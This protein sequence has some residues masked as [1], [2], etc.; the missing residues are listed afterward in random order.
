MRH[1]R[2]MF[3]KLQPFAIFALVLSAC[4]DP[5]SSELA[6][7]NQ[8]QK[9]PVDAGYVPAD[10]LLPNGEFNDTRCQAVAPSPVLTVGGRTVTFQAD[11]PGPRSADWTALKPILDPIAPSSAL[12]V[13]VINIVRVNGKPYFRYLSNGTQNDTVQTWSSSKPLA[14]A[15]MASQLR[16]ESNGLVGID[17]STRS[18]NGDG[19][20]VP[21]GD[22]VSIATVYRER[23]RPYNSNNIGTWAQ[24]VSGR[25]HTTRLI[26]TW[27]KRPN[28]TLGGGY[29]EDGSGLTA[30]FRSPD[31]REHVSRLS[32]SGST[33]NQ[34][35]TLTFADFYRRIILH[36]ELREQDLTENR[37]TCDPE[38]MGSL[39]LPCVTW[40]D[41]KTILYGASR[42]TTRYFRD[43][44]VGGMAGGMSTLLHHA[45]TAGNPQ[46]LNQRFQGK[47]RIFTKVGWGTSNGLPDTRWHGYGCFPVFDPTTGA[48][49][50]QGKEFLISVALKPLP[51]LTTAQ[52][53]IILQ[54]AVSAITSKLLDGSLK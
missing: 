43:K 32:A 13:T 38:R 23:V 50:A 10:L 52:A 54:K 25:P 27:L 9:N 35:S 51:G 33:A 17:G 22:L 7:Y 37:D 47:W 46:S 49:T 14:L 31:G 6:N 20:Q 11:G 12:K 28:E 2:S 29:G 41:M 8:L 39:S 26:N 4:G 44:A 18:T 48:S 5:S 40:S 1:V 42:N 21:I 24:N 30:T 34:I 36:R 16:D 19:G 45:A 53:D 15:A 3:M